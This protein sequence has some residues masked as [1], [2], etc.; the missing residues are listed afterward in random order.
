MTV[1]GPAGAWLAHAGLVAGRGPRGPTTEASGTEN[2]AAVA[3]PPPAAA[4]RAAGT[5][6]G[7]GA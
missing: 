1:G 6:A 7:G 4:A 2:D 5:G 3:G